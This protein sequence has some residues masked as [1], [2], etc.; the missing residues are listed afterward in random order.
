MIS[1]DN[2]NHW[3]NVYETKNPDQ[4]SWTQKKPQTSLDFILSS[5]L[6]KDA[7]IIDIGGGDSKL[8]DFLLEEGYENI[9]VLDIS[10]K[11]LEKAKKRLGD[12][13]VKVKWIVTD[14]TAFEPTETYDIWHD[15]AAFHFL[16]TSEQVSKY[17][18]IAE[19]NVNNFMILGTFS[20][21]GP[22]K[23]SG[24]DIQQYDEESLSEKFEKSFKKVNCI[25][26]DHTTPFDTVQNFVF[27]S[28][29][30]Q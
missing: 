24:L 5:G 22:T 8:V 7:S 10:A 4:V 2:K 21:N 25:T 19:K 13:A 14:I 29:K 16:T 9:T 20:K 28:F 12:A 17:I 26:E 3:E 30:K 1:S 11:S 27:C 23:C 15:R 18:D 6:G